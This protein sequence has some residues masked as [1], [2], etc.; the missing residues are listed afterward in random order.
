MTEEQIELQLAASSWLTKEADAL[1]KQW[2]SCKT[3]HARKKLIPK[4]EHMRARLRFEGR[5]IDKLIDLVD[6]EGEEWKQ[7]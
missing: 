4:L 1:I 7:T 5:G 6:G 3:A 2:K